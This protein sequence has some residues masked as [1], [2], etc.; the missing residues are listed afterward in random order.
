MKHDLGENFL[1]VKQRLYTLQNL[2][3]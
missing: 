1:F 2:L 3:T